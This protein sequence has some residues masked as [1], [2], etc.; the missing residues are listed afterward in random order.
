M[1]LRITI[2]FTSQHA[3]SLVQIHEALTRAWCLLRVESPEIACSSG[4]DESGNRYM[5]YQVPSSE[6]LQAWAKDTIILD[7]SRFMVSFLEARHRVR[8]QKS[9]GYSAFLHVSPEISDEN[10]LV[11]KIGIMFN[12]DHMYT[13]GIGIRIL[14][15]RFLEILGRVLTSEEKVDLDVETQVQNLSV[16]YT[17]LMNENQKSEGKSYESAVA[18]QKE[19]LLELVVSNPIGKC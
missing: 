14:A 19:F 16:P 10:G 15:G 8:Q 9:V 18:R 12:M 2:S 13:D 11:H 17:S 1:F 6:D 3:L 5:R 7:T 4:C